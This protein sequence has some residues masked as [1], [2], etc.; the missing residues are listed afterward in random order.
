M[1]MK[2][3]QVVVMYL[4]TDEIVRPVA[5]PDDVSPVKGI[6]SSYSFLFLDT[7]GTT[8]CESTDDGVRLVLWC[9]GVVMTVCHVISF[10]MFL[11][12]CGRSSLSGRK[13]SSP[14]CRFNTESE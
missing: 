1:N 5:P 9:E 2:I 10:W 3:N 4:D 13:S 14:C 8:V 12:V 7:P 6:L 11:G